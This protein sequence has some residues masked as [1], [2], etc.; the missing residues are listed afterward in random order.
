MEETGINKRTYIRLNTVFPVEFQFLYEHG[1]P[2]SDPFQGFARD[3]SKGGM[4]IETKAV[5]SRDIFTFIPG[6]TRLKLII[7]IPTSLVAIELYGTVSW[8]MEGSEQAMTLY[9]FGIDYDP[10]GIR[11]QKM[12]YLYFV[13]LHRR[14]RILLIVFILLLI[15]VAVLTFLLVMPV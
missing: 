9:K 13:W 1:E 10:V 15:T 2:L 3:V 14:P 5:R 8:Y 11:N 6:E 7:N 12:M 4:C